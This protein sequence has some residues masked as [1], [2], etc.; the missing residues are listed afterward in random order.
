M[1]NTSHSLHVVLY[2]RGPPSCALCS[3]ACT[4]ARPLPTARTSRCPSCPL[5][6]PPCHSPYLLHAPP[7][8]AIITICTASVH[9]PPLHTSPC[10]AFV[11]ACAMLLCTLQLHT[12]PHHPHRSHPCHPPCCNHN[13]NCGNST[14]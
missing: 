12:L 5:H 4:T 6:L 2:H 10:Y 3:C 1:Q 11:T 8:H 14:L 9:A 13:H 7:R